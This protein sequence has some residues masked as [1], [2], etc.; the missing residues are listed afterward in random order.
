METDHVL[1]EAELVVHVNLY[2]RQTLP[3]AFVPPSTFTLRLQ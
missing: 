3:S 1:S 2:E